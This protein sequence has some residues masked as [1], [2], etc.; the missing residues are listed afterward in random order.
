MTYIVG[1]SS[2]LLA[3]AHIAS[4]AGAVPLTLS[5]VLTVSILT[6]AAVF[7][8]KHKFNVQLLKQDN[9]YYCKSFLFNF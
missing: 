5:N 4:V 1:A 6:A 3:I 8:H 2:T 9:R 7:L